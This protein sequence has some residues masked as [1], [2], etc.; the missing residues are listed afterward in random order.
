MRVGSL[1]TG[2][3]GIDLGLECAGMEIAWQ[4]ENDPVCQ[5]ILQRRWPDVELHNDVRRKMRLAE[6]DMVAGGFPCQPVSTAGRRLGEADPRWLWPQF[7]KIIKQAQPRWVFIENVE[8]LR[9]R[10]LGSVLKGLAESGYDA[11]WDCLPAH[12]VGAPHAR[13]RYWIVANRNGDGSYWTRLH[14]GERP[15]VFQLAREGWSRLSSNGTSALGTS[16]YPHSARFQRLG[17]KRKLCQVAP[18]VAVSRFGWWESEPHVGRVV[19]GI[20]NRVD[21]IRQLGNS[22]VPQLVEVIGRAIL[23]ADGS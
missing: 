13:F 22:A 18:E 17:S 8:G 2:I 3:G 11:E 16:A 23:A 10:G 21:R 20:P 15:S 6:V 12:I 4:I 19:Y 14:E 5:A 9:V 1:F 7:L